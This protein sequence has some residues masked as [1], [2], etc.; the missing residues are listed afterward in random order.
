MLTRP[1]SQNRHH[2]VPTW[3][4]ESAPNNFGYIG[5]LF[6]VFVFMINID[7]KTKMLGKEKKMRHKKVPSI[8]DPYY[9]EWR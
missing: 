4:T 6:S 2:G 8:S 9:I 7:D 5:F 1:K 3:V